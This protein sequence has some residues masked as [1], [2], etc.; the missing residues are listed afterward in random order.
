MFDIKDLMTQAKVMQEKVRLEQE[1]LA[2]TEYIG[3]AGGQLVTVILSGKG[4]M[5][6][7]QLDPS[8]LKAEEKEVLEDLIIAACNEAKTKVDSASASLISGM[9]GGINLP[10]GFKMPG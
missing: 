10:P 9:M 6:K 2:A 7:I 5:R 3:K 8:L 4:E 1:K